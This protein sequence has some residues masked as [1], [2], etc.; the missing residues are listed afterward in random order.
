MDQN[1]PQIYVVGGCVRDALLGRTPK[2]IDYVVVGGNEQWMIDNGFVKIDA[3]S[4]PVFH[5]DKRN[6]YAL[7]RTETKTSAGYH[8]FEVNVDDVSLE[9]D[10]SRRDLTINAMAVRKAD[11]KKFCNAKTIA[12]KQKYL[13]D[14]FNG[15]QDLNEGIL[16]HVSN[17]FR[18]DPVR[19]LRIARFAAR[20][21]FEVHEDTYALIRDMN[22]SGELDSLIVDRV[23]NELQRA[24]MEPHA[25]NFFEVLMR[26]GVLH[27]TIWSPSAVYEGAERYDDVRLGRLMHAVVCN[28]PLAVRLVAVGFVSSQIERLKGPKHII[29][30]IKALEDFEKRYASFFK[31]AFTASMVVHLME[32]LKVQQAESPTGEMMIELLKFKAVIDD[33]P[34]LHRAVSKRA[35]DQFRAVKL[36]D[37]VDCQPQERGVIISGLRRQLIEQIL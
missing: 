19:A 25:H 26:A 16:R 9:Q 4:F 2:D 5:D 27:K 35:I 14:P 6:E 30:F 1:E 34:S 23:W 18:E 24:I 3:T 7:A 32:T 15:Q 11:W 28:M 36:P 10:L 22:Q 21:D 12:K 17:A 20:Y 8:G 31:T 33:C 13:I 29:K 37:N